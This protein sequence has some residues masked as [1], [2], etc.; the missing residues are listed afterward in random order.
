MRY[1][2]RFFESNSNKMEEK[3]DFLS[4][5][6]DEK[7]IDTKD[8]TD[9][10][11]YIEYSNLTT[12][13]IKSLKEYLNGDRF[14]DVIVFIP[15]KQRLD[16]FNILIVD[17]EF[18]NKNLNI[19]YKNIKWDEHPIYKELKRTS[20]GVKVD[21]LL[22]R[23]KDTKKAEELPNGVTMIKNMDR[24]GEIEIWDSKVMEDPVRIWEKDG[25]D[26]VTLQYLLYKHCGQ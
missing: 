14:R 4:T 26:M 17:D 10:Y 15:E 3:F 12:D 18:Y 6:I 8:I 23:Y 25:N 2:K 9:K 20:T 19:L 22:D 11:V 1:I 7:N 16:F 5:H 21:F 24:P 13:E